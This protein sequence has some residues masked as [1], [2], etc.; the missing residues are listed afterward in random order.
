MTTTVDTT[1]FETVTC[2]YC[3]GT[4]KDRWNLLSAL[5]RCSACTGTGTHIVQ[6]PYRACA[7][8]A[9]T[10]RHPHLRVTCTTCRGAGVVHVPDDACVC[11]RCG[12]R[13]VD[14]QSELDLSCLR[15][16][17]TGWTM[18]NGRGNHVR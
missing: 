5:S 4:G 2:A 9:G 12:G 16:G 14:P 3:G 1:V 6:A 18:S 11:S 13:G 7:H 15:C 17:G 8:C 10:G